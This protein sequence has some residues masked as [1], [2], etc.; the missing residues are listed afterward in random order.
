MRFVVLGWSFHGIHL[1]LRNG[2]GDL[3]LLERAPDL[4]SQFTADLQ[5]VKGIA[6]RKLDFAGD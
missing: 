2:N 6:N 5:N 3:V 4:L 1:S